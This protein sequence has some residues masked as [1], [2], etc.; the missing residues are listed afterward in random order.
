VLSTVT[1]S[2][3]IKWAVTLVFIITAALNSV[4]G[5]LDSQNVEEYDEK[6]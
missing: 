3:E 1:K 4:G 2:V 5:T 6:V